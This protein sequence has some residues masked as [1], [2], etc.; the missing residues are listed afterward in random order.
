M[1]LCIERRTCCFD[2]S[3]PGSG[4]LEAGLHRVPLA[5]ASTNDDDIRS[6]RYESNCCRSEYPWR[7]YMAIIPRR[8]LERDIWGDGENLGSGQKNVATVT[9]DPATLVLIEVL[10]TTIH[11]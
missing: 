11:G 2:T 10:G 6:A 3:L 1:A 4:S 7:E 8:G 9:L 5:E